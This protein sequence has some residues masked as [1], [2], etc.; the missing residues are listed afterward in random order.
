MRL[1]GITEAQHYC[2]SYTAVGGDAEGPLKDFQRTYFK[3][4]G[5]AITEGTTLFDEYRSCSLRDIERLL[6]LAASQYRRCL[7]LMIPS[8][9]PWAH[10]TAYYGCFFAARALLGMFGGTIF[11]YDVV[12]VQK[13]MPGQQELMLRG[14]NKGPSPELTT[15]TGSHERFWDL[16]YKAVVPLTPLVPLH[17]AVAL[18]PVSGD[19]TWQTDRRNQ[20]NYETYS[21]LKLSRDFQLSFSQAGFPKSLPGVLATQYGIFDCMLELTFD[22]AKQFKIETDALAGLGTVGVRGGKIRRLIYGARPPALI[23]KT[24]KRL[25]L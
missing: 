7:D 21:A 2:A 25:L 15:Y 22:F 8:A 14:I 11:G 6:F 24:K 12:D 17:L 9:S 16:F 19:P 3:R 1:F 20:V 13:S 18:T 5:M 23:S 10:V 4:K